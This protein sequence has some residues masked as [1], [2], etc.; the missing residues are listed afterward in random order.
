MEANSYREDKRSK[1]FSFRVF[2][3]VL[4]FTCYKSSTLP[5]SP[6]LIWIPTIF[7]L[8]IPME[9]PEQT[10]A[11]QISILQ[12][13]IKV[14][15]VWNLSGMIL[16]WSSCAPPNLVQVCRQTCLLLVFLDF[17]YYHICSVTSGE[18]FWKFAYGLTPRCVYTK[19][20]LTNMADR[21]PS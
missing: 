21:G 4:S 9:M 14:Y 8:S 20:M 5:Y 16:C 6:S 3:S 11:I 1:Y 10:V 7:T 17:S 18:I 2:T 19:M 12:H 15:T 13:L